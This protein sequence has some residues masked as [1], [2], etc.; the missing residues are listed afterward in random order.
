MSSTAISRARPVP[1]PASVWRPWRAM[2]PCGTHRPGTM[3]PGPLPPLRHASGGPVPCVPCTRPSMKTAAARLPPRPGRRSPSSATGRKPG[4]SP[5]APCWRSLPARHACPSP[6]TTW[7]RKRTSCAIS[8]ARPS[9]TVPSVTRPTAP[10]PKA[11]MPAACPPTAVKAAKTRPA[12]PPG[13]MR[14]AVAMTRA[15]ASARSLRGASVSRRN[16]SSMRKRSRSRR[17]RAPSPVKA[18]SCPPTRSRW[19]SPASGPPCPVSLWSPRRRIMTSTPSKTWRSSST[20]CATSILRPASPSSWWPKTA[21]GPSPWA[22]PR[23]ARTAWSS[24]AMTAVPVPA[25]IPPS[26]MW[27]CRGNPACP[28]RIRPW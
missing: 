7:S 28:K 11:A 15:P 17:P 1:S 9:P 16:I 27:A 5:S 24:P 20:T 14:T 3:P 21:S 26:I 4:A 23:P 19:T 18:A 22:W 25:P 8:S 12:T 10:W 6:W 13:R 2:P